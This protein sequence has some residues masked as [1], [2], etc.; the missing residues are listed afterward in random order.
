MPDNLLEELERLTTAMVERQN[1]ALR[2]VASR[3]GDP[4][5]IEERL[6]FL[7]WRAQDTAVTLKDFMLIVADMER[8]R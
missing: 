7:E 8:S 3:Y 5:P 1:A 4:P 2:D 6:R